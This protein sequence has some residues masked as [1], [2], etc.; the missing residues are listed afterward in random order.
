MV[1]S[2]FVKPTVGV[3]YGPGD[4]EQLMY[5]DA[6]AKFVGS[7]ILCKVQKTISFCTKLT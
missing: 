2:F 3:P 5:Q 6:T 7:D 1:Y 4:K